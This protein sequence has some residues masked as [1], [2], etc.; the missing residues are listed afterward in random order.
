MSAEGIA[1]NSLIAD[2]SGEVA[3]LC[4]LY[5]VE[6]LDLFGSA[7]SGEFHPESSDLDFIVAY[8]PDADP[9]PWFSKHLELQAA[10]VRVFD[11]PVDLVID[12]PFRNPYFAKAVAEIRTS[13]YTAQ[14]QQVPARHS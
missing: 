5:Q 12:Q 14:G 7:A 11:R 6:R 1:V 10:L 2:H 9:D 3:E 13:L 4:R 8:R